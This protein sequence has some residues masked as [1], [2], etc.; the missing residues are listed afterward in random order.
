MN[1]NELITNRT[2]ADIDMALAFIRNNTPLP[3]NNLK[4]AWD[5]RALQRIE[6]FCKYLSDILVT[7]GYSVNI[8]T[9]TDWTKESPNSEADG[10][11]ILNNLNVLRNVF[12]VFSTTPNTPA[13]PSML[14]FSD[15]NDIEQI[16]FDIDI[17][18]EML[19]VD[20]LFT[21]QF[22]PGADKDDQHF[23]EV[24]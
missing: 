13:M 4:I 6:T 18:I 15:A 24:W 2:Q 10:L 22:Y 11:R 20:F 19:E 17:L 7:Y 12:T 3:A 9:K 21:G 8:E 14:N 16:L 5:W 1:R 23:E